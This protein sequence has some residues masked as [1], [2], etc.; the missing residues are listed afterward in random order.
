MWPLYLGCGVTIKALVLVSGIAYV[1]IPPSST[2]D[3]SASNLALSIKVVPLPISEVSDLSV[4]SV[5]RT[6][7]T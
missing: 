6:S 7:D 1:S 4:V 3:N 2:I 5:K